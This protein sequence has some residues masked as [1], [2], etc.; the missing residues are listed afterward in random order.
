MLTTYEHYLLLTYLCNAASRLNPDGPEAAGLADWLKDYGSTIDVVVGPCDLRVTLEQ[1]RAAAGRVRPDVIGRLLRRLGRQ[2]GLSR[3][4]VRIVELML[5][6]ETRQFFAAMVEAVFDRGPRRFHGQ[7]FALGRPALPTLLGVSRSGCF[8]RLAGD[9]PLVRTGVVYLYDRDGEIGLVERLRR[10]A[11]SAPDGNADPRELLFDPAPESELEWSD[12]DHVAGH[13]DHVERLLR[14]ALVAREA[15]VNILIYGPPGTGK[16]AFCRTLAQRLDVALFGV[17]EADEDGLEPS[18]RERIQEF[19]LS[20]NVLGT[21][22]NS[23][24]LF[25]EMEDLL[26]EPLQ[27]SSLAE[28]DGGLSGGVGSKVFMN[29]MLERNPIPTLWTSNAVR[30]TSPALLR[31][32][33]FALELRHPSAQIRSRVWQRQL[34]RQGIDFEEGEPASLA[35]DYDVAPGVVASA[36]A[37]ARLVGQ[38]HMGAVRRGVDSLSRLIHGPRPRRAAPVDFDPELL[39]T[40]VDPSGLADSL[41]QAGR[42]R[43]ALCLQGPP[44]TGKSAYARYLAERMGLEVVQKRTSDLLSMWMGETE[45]AS[46][47]HSPRHATASSFSCSTRR[48]RCSPTDDSRSARGRCLRSTRC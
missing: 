1:A 30:R 10:L 31:R 16:T 45:T 37:A 3:L 18:R 33:M 23:L 32:M 14:G 8:A 20:Q 17:G 4:D 35:M 11:R 24:L 46:H 40:D 36:T 39:R 29:R 44:G 42:R 5:R 6:C 21:D 43:C 19:R 47:R 34:R 25:D 9:A 28:L 15:G 7:L 2:L 38:D 13:R 27:A 41:A 26:P 48:T 22:G 12:F